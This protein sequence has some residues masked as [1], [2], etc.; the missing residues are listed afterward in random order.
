DAGRRQHGDG[1]GEGPHEPGPS[2]EDVH[3]AAMSRRAARWLVLTIVVAVAV[4]VVLD[5]LGPYD[6]PHVHR[7]SPPPRSR[8]P[9]HDVLFQIGRLVDIHGFY[10]N[11]VYGV[12]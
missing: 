1:H 9:A 7:P 11:M 6:V 3:D 4:Y 2:A 12:R 8:L 10:Q 5:R